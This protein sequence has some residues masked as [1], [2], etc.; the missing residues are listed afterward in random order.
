MYIQGAA[1]WHPRCGPGPGA[2]IA[3]ELDVQFDNQVSA[4]MLLGLP[5]MLQHGL[6]A[7]PTPNAFALLV[8]PNWKSLHVK[9]AISF[10]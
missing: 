5:C 10:Y 3:A 9:H 6:D 8:L 2:K 7:S 1:I 4:V